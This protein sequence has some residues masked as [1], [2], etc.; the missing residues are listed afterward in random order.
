MP[1]YTEAEFAVLVRR[2]GLTLDDRQRAAL[3]EVMPAF[4]TMLERA[5]GAR[6]AGRDR[7][8]EP[9]HIFIPGQ[10]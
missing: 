3:H 2:A 10:R 7:A 9:A 1:A 6:G 4:E 5:R 8:A